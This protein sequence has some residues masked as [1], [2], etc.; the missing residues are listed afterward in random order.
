MRDC[1]DNDKSDEEQNC[2]ECSEFECEN[3][4]CVEYDALCN[5][6]NNCGCVYWSF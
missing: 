3:G 1:G 4:V 2:G 5:G 6:I